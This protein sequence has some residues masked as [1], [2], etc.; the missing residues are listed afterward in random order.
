MRT[1]IVWSLIN[2]SDLIHPNTS[3]TANNQRVDIIDYW[4]HW[5][6]VIR[7]HFL[8]SQ[9]HRVNWD[10]TGLTGSG[11]QKSPQSEV[12]C[13]SRSFFM[14]FCRTL[15]NPEEPWRTMK[16]PEEPWRNLRNHLVLD[17]PL[18]WPRSLS[19]WC[20]CCASRSPCGS[21]VWPPSCLLLLL[22]LL[23]N[24]YFTWTF[25]TS[26]HFTS[27][28]PLVSADRLQLLSS[29]YV[30]KNLKLRPQT[31]TGSVSSLCASEYNFLFAL[32]N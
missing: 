11:S 7:G 30:L 1:V 4:K 2:I 13:V 5:H 6:D 24:F 16:N 3:L 23:H 15:K 22:L 25:F 29:V 14:F 17:S 32:S 9:C 28:P 8:N 26:L 21:S 19:V 10:W 31:Q 12:D 18:T 27:S 20:S